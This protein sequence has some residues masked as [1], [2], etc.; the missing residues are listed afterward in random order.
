MK[1]EINKQRHIIIGGTTKAGTTS[2]YDYL[3]KHPEV[4]ASS[5][6][7][8]RFFLDDKYP[9]EVKVRYSQGVHRYDEL[10]NCE[11]LNQV[12][13]E[14]SPDYL[15]CPETAVIIKNTLDKVKIIFILRDPIGRL[16]SW[17]KFGIMLGILPR[18]TTFEQYVR[19]Q[20]DRTGE[21]VS[22]IIHPAF[23]ALQQG[24]YSEYVAKYLDMF[25]RDDIL[26]CYYEQLKSDPVE[27]MQ[28]MCQFIGINP[29]YYNDYQFKIVNKSV[30]PR[31]VFI[32]NMQVKTRAFLRTF[33]RD[34]PKVEQLYAWISSWIEP[35]YKKVNVRNAEEVILKEQTLVLLQQYYGN[36]IAYFEK[37]LG[38]RPPWSN[39]I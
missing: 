33:K 10:F 13:L 18:E 37:L 30:D 2:V 36:E 20:L 28:T 14:A 24:R 5:E 26:I 6:K 16:K 22:D 9:L 3:S 1:S 25:K 4:C 32:H 23:I 31:S 29:G 19:D 17:F 21:D 27:F 35:I 7:E 38:G 39:L 12:R 34:R 8:T 15:H 11:N